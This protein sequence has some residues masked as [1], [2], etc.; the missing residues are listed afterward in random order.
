M[1]VR[2]VP[3]LAPK[4]VLRSLTY[5]SQVVPRFIDDIISNLKLSPPC[6]LCAFC[7]PIELFRTCRRYTDK[8]I[9]NKHLIITVI[10]LSLRFGCFQV[11]GFQGGSGDGLCGM[12]SSKLPEDADGFFCLFVW[13]WQNGCF[14]K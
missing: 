10:T 2:F 12:G 6:V 9:D 11:R 5:C 13:W 1:Q 8:H 3:I 14:Q 7:F 4:K